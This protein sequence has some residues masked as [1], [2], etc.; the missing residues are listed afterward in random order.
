MSALLLKN[1]C[2]KEKH[3]NQG[4]FSTLPQPITDHSE[5]AIPNSSVFYN[6]ELEN[7]HLLID[8]RCDTGF[9]KCG[10]DNTSIKK[11]NLC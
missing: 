5:H 1:A 10:S 8:L 4:T 11:R 7:Y 3:K 6:I 9:Q 2:H